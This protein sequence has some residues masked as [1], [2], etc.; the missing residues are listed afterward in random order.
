MFKIA[1]SGDCNAR[2]TRSDKMSNATSWMENHTVCHTIRFLS[3]EVGWNAFGT[4]FQ[5]E[6][7]DKSQP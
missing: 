1:F 2:D 4:A 7:Y 6:S 3:Y 5:K